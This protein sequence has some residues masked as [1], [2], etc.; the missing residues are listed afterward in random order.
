[1][2]GPPVKFNGSVKLAGEFGPTIVI[3]IRQIEIILK[4]STALVYVMK[5]V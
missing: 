2:V 4:D 1:M 5:S 3:L